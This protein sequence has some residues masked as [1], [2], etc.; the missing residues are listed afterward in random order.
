MRYV[1]LGE[2]SDQL[3]LADDDRHPPH[4]FLSH[5]PKRVVEV[6]VGRERN[7][8]SRGHVADHRGVGIQPRRA[9]SRTVICAVTARGRCVI[10][11]EIFVPIL[12]PFV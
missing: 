5:E 11:S 8:V 4:L 10:T 9:A 3:V 1:G 7:D 2:H 6:V 12:A